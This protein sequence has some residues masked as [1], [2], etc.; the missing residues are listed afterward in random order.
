MSEIAFD[1]YC[2]LSVN[3]QSLLDGEGDDMWSLIWGNGIYSVDKAYQQLI[4][5]EY[6]HPAFKWS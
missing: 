4:S 2:E 5:D 6:V 1:Q 3:L